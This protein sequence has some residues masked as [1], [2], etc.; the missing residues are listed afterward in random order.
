MHITQLL[1][2][3]QQQNNSLL[4][5]GLDPDTAKLPSTIKNA[6]DAQFSF[7][8]AIIDA[9]HDL[10]CAY[11]PNAAFYEAQGAQGIAQLK[12][13]FDYLKQQYPQI[14]VIL[15]AKRGDIGNTNEGYVQFA[16][17]Y[18][19]A[20]AIT[21]HPYLGK[22]AMQ[23]FLDQAE[24]GCIIMC[25][26]SNPG[27]G[28]F[29]NLQLEGTEL[30]KHIAKQISTEWNTNNNCMLVVGATY[31]QELAE[32]RNIVGDSMTILVPGVGTQGGDV[33]ETVQNGKN[34][35]GRGLIISA[36]RSVIFASSNEDFAEKAREEAQKLRDSINNFR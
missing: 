30:Y 33:Q 17:D 26:N 36:S 14:P 5:V 34:T 8:K 7:N 21:L 23:P 15:D 10:V 4:C 6:P 12:K 28:E 9:T 16:F 31:P 27:S 11:K 18:L 2:V 1:D 24:K 22:E 29:Q 13:T 32:V 20:D 19:H 35:A 3:I 25:R